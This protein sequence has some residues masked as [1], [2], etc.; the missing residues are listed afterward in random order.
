M[1]LMSLSILALDAPARG[2]SDPAC[3]GAEAQS[4]VIA[5]RAELERTPDVLGKRIK[6]SDLLSDAGCYAE[7]IALL[8]AGEA[9]QP[10]NSELQYRL[11]RVRSM[12]KEKSYFDGMDR[13]AASAELRRSLVRCAQ[14]ADLQAC[15]A[16][17]AEQPG[18]AD[19]A[20][21]K[22]DALIKSNRV[23]EAIAAY[24][25]AAQLAPDNAL[26][27]SRLQAAQ[28]QRQAMQHSCTD[29]SGEP[30]LRACQAIMTRG[31]PNEF[32]LTLR[33]AFLQQSVNRPAQALDSYIAANSLRPGNTA[34]ALAMLALI[35]STQRQDAVG[36]AARGSALM[37]LGR[38]AD[39][40]TALKGAS[41]LAPGM[42]DIERQLAAAEDQARIHS[43]LQAQAV[44]RKPPKPPAA[45][46]AMPK[47]VPVKVV[48]E[49][50]PPPPRAS[51]SNDEP[52][53]QSN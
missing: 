10:H 17:A 23:D 26:I 37:T 9:L 32:D 12:I 50:A 31:S 2:A 7:A 43:A 15:D 8:E 36:L 39:A 46:V 20:F 27:A 45:R 3:S 34:V 11:N 40:V 35:D 5:A 41:A 14:L 6:L 24:S 22:G 28:S 47:P 44:A 4:D 53:S 18:N 29:E 42:P 33:M 30:A 48:D 21:A 51:Y 1:A 49:A 52:A 19:I 25:H 38:A 13:A 16:A